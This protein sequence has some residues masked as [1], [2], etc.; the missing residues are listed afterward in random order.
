M[1]SGGGSPFPSVPASGTST[2]SNLNP[3]A[4]KRTK[5]CV[6]CG[7]C[8]GF[9]PAHMEAARALA[10]VMAANNIQLGNPLL[11]I[12]LSHQKKHQLTPSQSTEAAQS[13]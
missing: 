10:R 2:P 9:D 11:P 5:I 6:Y 12:P 13:A 7:S 8:P 3:N 1:A 4:P